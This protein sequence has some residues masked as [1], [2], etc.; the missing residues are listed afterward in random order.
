MRRERALNI[1]LE[2]QFAMTGAKTGDLIL[3]QKL[4]R[5]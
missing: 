2:I 4:L 3:F 5:H 1:R